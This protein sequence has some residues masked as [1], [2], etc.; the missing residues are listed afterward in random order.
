MLT[1]RTIFIVANMQGLTNVA[2]LHAQ[3]SKTLSISQS[4]NTILK[5]LNI[6]SM[7]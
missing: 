5:H 1:T 7:L 6:Y 3:Y 2:A 4:N